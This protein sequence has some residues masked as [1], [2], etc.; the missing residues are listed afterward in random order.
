MFE[1]LEV[2]NNPSEQRR[3]VLILGKTNTGKST[4]LARAKMPMAVIDDDHRFSQ[5][6]DLAD[7]KVYGRKVGDGYTVDD[8]LDWLEKN[9]PGSNTAS[10]GWDSI[11][12]VIQPVIFKA[13]DLAD[14]TP[15]ERKEATGNPSKLAI[16]EPKNRLFQKLHSIQNYGTDVYW[17]GHFSQ[18]SELKNGKVKKIEKMSVSEAEYLKFGKVLNWII[19]TVTG[20]KNGQTYYGIKF[21]FAR[22][23]ND[24]VN[25][26]VWDEPGNMFAGMWERLDEMYAG[27]DQIP[28]VEEFLSYGS[29]KAF[30]SQ[31]VALELATEYH[32]V[33]RD[34]SVVYPFGDPKASGTVNKAKNSYNRIKQGKNP[35]YPKPPP[36]KQGGA[37]VMAGTWVQHVKTKTKYALYQYENPPAPD[38][39][40]AKVEAQV[41]ELAGHPPPVEDEVPF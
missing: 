28:P 26:I 1:E 15:D 11:T 9:M 14:M 41:A 35:D 4:L 19:Q 17:L 5:V 38:V 2:V 25:K 7:G 32:L 29:E 39:D 24:L 12:P 3:A 22:G 16:W 20:V 10:I 33:A 34:G 6:S 13:M 21:L 23:R 30:P 40:E 36:A 37:K 31:A 27:Q 8:S 18:S